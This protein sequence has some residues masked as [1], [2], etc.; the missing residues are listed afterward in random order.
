MSTVSSHLLG[1]LS[2]FR[3]IFR[4]S[5]TPVR[6]RSNIFVYSSIL[7]HSVSEGM[8]KR[9]LTQNRHYPSLKWT[10]TISSSTTAHTH[11]VSCLRRRMKICVS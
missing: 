6:D 4:F 5:T 1:I 9:N 3:I 11:S 8:Q 2:V 7:L 10:S